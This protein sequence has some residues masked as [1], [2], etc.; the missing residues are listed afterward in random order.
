VDIYPLQIH[1]SEI[2][3]TM[4]WD[5]L[6]PEDEQDAKRQVTILTCSRLFVFQNSSHPMFSSFTVFATEPSYIPLD[7][8]FVHKIISSGKYISSV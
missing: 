5:Y 8:H 7:T 6:F 1:L 4:M 3:Y 2:L